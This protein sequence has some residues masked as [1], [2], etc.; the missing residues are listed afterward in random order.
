[1]QQKL[2][3]LIT[4]NMPALCAPTRE[5]GADTLRTPFLNGNTSKA[6][7]SKNFSFGINWY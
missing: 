4:R 2:D 6:I 5:V 7:L 1:M 3:S